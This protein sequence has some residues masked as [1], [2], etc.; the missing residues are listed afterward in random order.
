MK[1]KIIEKDFLTAIKNLDD[2]NIYINFEK[3]FLSLRNND[4]IILYLN[5]VNCEN[6]SNKAV[7]VKK[8]DA[9]KFKRTKKEIEIE[10]NGESIIFIRDGKVFYKISYNTIDYKKSKPTNGLQIDLVNL[11]EFIKL[12]KTIKP[13]IFY[14]IFG[15]CKFNIANDINVS[16]YSKNEVLILKQKVN[17]E[18][19]TDEFDI[20]IENLK[21]LLDLQKKF[22]IATEENYLYN[23]KKSIY[24]YNSKFCVKI[25][26]N[27]NNTNYND[28]VFNIIDNPKFKNFELKDFE[29][30]DKTTA[31]IPYKKK[32][33]ELVGYQYIDSKKAVIFQN[34]ENDAILQ[35]IITKKKE[36]I[37]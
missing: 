4:K 10:L 16:T 2:K 29:E 11:T 13:D 37:D 18:N 1:A 32:I 14:K 33:K 3:T 24:L 21:P 5:Y 36:A 27:I 34:I 31:D 22:I 28:L 23:S 7:C 15:V 6:Q 25:D 20:S 19:Q 26:K 17:Q 30:V 12:A 9:T 8:I 35:Y